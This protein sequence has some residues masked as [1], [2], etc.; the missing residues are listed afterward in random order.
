MV[1]RAMAILTKYEIKDAHI[2]SKTLFPAVV[3]D[4]ILLAL[5]KI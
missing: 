4:F 2:H 1:I 5:I 3:L